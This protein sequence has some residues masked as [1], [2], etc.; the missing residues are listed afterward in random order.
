MMPNRPFED[1]RHSL[2]SIRDMGTSC[3]L[4]SVFPPTTMHLKQIK[5]RRMNIVLE[6]CIIESFPTHAL[7]VMSCVI[8]I[9]SE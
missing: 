2:L 9:H 3:S 7:I 8:N 5:S 1:N 6:D 4:C